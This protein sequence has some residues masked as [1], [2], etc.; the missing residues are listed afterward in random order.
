M[1]GAGPSFDPTGW[2]IRR[3]S[4]DPA[5]NAYYESLLGLSNG[6]IG[7]RATADFD[8]PGRP[9]FFHMDVYGPALTVPAHL[10]N[11]FNPTLRRLTAGGLP[12]DLTMAT[13][14]SQWLDLRTGQMYLDTT[15][16]DRRGRSTRLV[17]ETFLPAT[18]PEVIATR[19]AVTRL[20]HNADVV[21]TVGIDWSTGN[22]DF[23][24]T[25]HRVRLHHLDPP[26]RTW[27]TGRLLI[28]ADNP[29]NGERVA[30][31]SAVLADIAVA[32]RA[33]A[34]GSRHLAEALVLDPTAAPQVVT[35]LTAVR[36]GANARTDA[37]ADTYLREVVR[38]GYDAL[39]ANHDRIWRE[40]WATATEVAGTPEVVEGW[41]YAQFQLLQ[42]VDRGRAVTNQPARGL[43]S[44]YHSGHFF[45]NSELFML[46]YLACVAPDVAKAMLR[47]RIG[48]LDAAIEHGHVTGYAGAR[49]PEEA[50]RFGRPSS[51][52]TI[53][54]PFTRRSYTELSGVQ[55]KHLS[56]DVLHAL[57]G[58]LE[59]TGDDAFL[60]EE[61]MPLVIAA[62][63][64][65][66]DLM[67][68]DRGLGGRGARDVMGFDEYHYGV[69][70]H[71]GTNLLARWALRWAAD[72]VDRTAPGSGASAHWRQVADEIYFPPAKDGVIP[73]FHGY[74]ELPDQ[75]RQ[76]ASGHRLPILD[77]ADAE[78]ATLLQSF[79]TRLAKQSDVVFAMILVPDS[80]ADADLACNLAFYEPRTVHES[81]LSMTAHGVA[82][83]RLGQCELATG[84][85][86]ASARYNLDFT[87][88][89]DY[90]NGVHLA[91]YAGAWLVLFQG[92]LNGRVDGSGLSIAPRLPDGVKRLRVP[93]R[94]HGRA[95]TIT[96]REDACIV[97]ADPGNGGPVSVRVGSRWAELAP[98]ESWMEGIGD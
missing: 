90:D 13:A 71:F 76:Q 19:I 40:R 28:A 80:F 70:H 12:L 96:V 41:R 84:L 45:F 73:I 24:G 88:R 72:T 6:R 92:F 79:R 42:S 64:Y 1:T 20:D 63:T 55:V 17:V 30:M 61:A 27:T 31:A 57:A 94:V 82:A 32:D 97:E 75:I 50:D 86:L 47:F 81:S 65:L 2:T 98:G 9:G 51:P 34:R 38:L 85:F 52:T 36:V 16:V 46:P 39:R 18:H 26:I 15:L 5:E 25:H 11:L 3:T 95:L 43:T 29:P 69:D 35:Q 58:Y 66:A 77:E 4:Y 93:V 44:E 67:R 8:A 89:H 62:A 54:D 78:R 37:E 22:G 87:N 23:G 53:T 10:V 7:L 21:L 83:A 33:P 48:T 74:F 56:A 49:F 59:T 14:F 91:A 60:S 68:P